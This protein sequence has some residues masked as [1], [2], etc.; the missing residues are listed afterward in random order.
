MSSEKI[1]IRE[2]WPEYFRKKSESYKL[3]A[4]LMRLCRSLDLNGDEDKVLEVW[5][6]LSD[7]IEKKYL[8][9]D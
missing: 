4:A 1:E 5:G 2:N 3:C 7:R 9:V 6:H 8:G